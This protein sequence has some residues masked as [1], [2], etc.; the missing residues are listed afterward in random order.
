MRSGVK[1]LIATF[2]WLGMMWLMFWLSSIVGFDLSNTQRTGWWGFPWF[3]TVVVVLISS[4]GVL[5][6]WSSPMRELHGRE[7]K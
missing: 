3:V 2:V 4:A 6:W 5:C 7:R 1:A